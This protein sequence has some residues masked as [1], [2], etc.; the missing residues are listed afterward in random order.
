MIKNNKAITLIA[1][2]IMIIVILILAGVGTTTGLNAIRETK[3]YNAVSN[4]KVMQTKINEIYEEYKY[5]D[6]EGK[7][8]IETYGQE[9]TSNITSDANI[10]YNSAKN[11][12][13]TGTDIGEFEDFRLYTSNYIKE[14]LDLDNMDSDYLINIKTRTVI[15]LDG[16]IQDGIK[17]YSLG[18]IEGEQYNVEYINP[19]VTI[20]TNGG[21]FVLKDTGRIDNIITNDELKIKLELQYVPADWNM[22]LKYVWS[23]SKQNSPSEGWISYT[24][25][26]N[27]TE[28]I[29]VD[30]DYYLWVKIIKNEGTDTEEIMKTTVSNKYIIKDKYSIMIAV[31]F[32]A[33]G[34]TVDIQN[35]YYSDN[36]VYG[37]L[38]IPTREGYTFKG[39]STSKT[40]ETTETMV[41]SD[42][43]VYVET[44]SPLQPKIKT[45]YACWIPYEFDV[46]FKNS[47]PDE[48]QEVE[49]IES[50]G[51]QYI[52][53]N[54]ALWNGSN[55]KIENKFS[56]NQHYN[57][58]NMFGVTGVTDTNNEMWIASDKKYYIRVGGITKNAIGVIEVDTPYTIIHDNSG[59]KYNVYIEGEL[60]KT[61]NKSNT[62]SDKIVLYGHRD[63]GKYLNGKTYYLKLWK[64]SQLMRYFIPCYKMGNTE[65][66]G[67][68]DIVNNI[69][70][71]NAGTGSY[72]RGN[73]VT[74]DNYEMSTQHFTYGIQQELQTY[75]KTREGY[76]FVGWNTKADGTGTHYNDSESVSNLTTQNNGK[77]NLYAQWEEEE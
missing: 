7:N 39:W 71:T 66:N 76:V 29:T 21:I 19:D 67:L 57:Y 25:E 38:P 58:N 16:M 77:V 26:S 28:S 74:K 23:T 20:S 59:E 34:G 8:R 41:N 22:S 6:T 30:G 44:S 75:N 52:N 4:L 12:N 36:E 3:F 37:E 65:Q 72:T 63:G 50:S 10:A 70:Y 53:T 56:V 68:Y 24:G 13:L 69:F 46:I 45:L 40:L 60:A 73:N 61:F 27:V 64:D 1:L 17:Y 62:N 9:I 2:I 14:N 54:L 18:E 51:N 35:K 15:L 49:Y 42:S 43:I 55:W 47:I 5:T 32:D 31:I 11:N 33:N 48:Y